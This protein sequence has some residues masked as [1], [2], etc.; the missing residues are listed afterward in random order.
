MTM[1]DHPVDE[2]YEPVRSRD[3]SRI[4]T[5]TV[6]C[7][8]IH[9]ILS[10]KEY[11]MNV[12]MVLI[13][14]MVFISGL[15]ASA[16]DYK[17]GD[18][19][20]RQGSQSKLWFQGE[21]LDVEGSTITIGLWGWMDSDPEVV[22]DMAR[23]RKLS[24]TKDVIIRKNG[25]VWATVSPNGDIRVNGSIAGSINGDDGTIRKSGSM[26]GE[27]Y[28]HGAIRKSGSEVGAIESGG[29]LRRNGQIIGSINNQDGTI[30]LN[31]SIIGGIDGFAHTFRE[32]RLAAAVLAFF[33]P[34]FGY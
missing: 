33:A 19:I 32:M 13:P 2:L 8:I 7:T 16:A 21:V 11:H 4:L 12:R 26:V 10:E 28:F 34:E 27:I 15:V 25:S 23:L 22:E 5:I 30:R 17:K 31:G 20:E 9:S 3:V 29:D 1:N 18:F 14:F 6:L 24:I